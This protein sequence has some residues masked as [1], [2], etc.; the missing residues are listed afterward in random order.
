MTTA[1]LPQRSFEQTFNNL[2][3]DFFLPSSSFIR[4]DAGKW[5]NG[6]NAP[7]NIQKTEHGYALELV[8]PGFSKEEIKI[9]L[10]KN[11]LTISGVQESKEEKE[12]D[13]FI[14]KEFRRQSF[15]R[16]F[17]LDESIDAENISARYQDGILSLNLPKK[18]AVKEPVKQITI[19]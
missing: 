13:Q 8:A 15:K 6:L 11:I 1:R 4:N 10:D 19:Q 18:A 9:D 2:L 17:T 5:H 16:S 12:A 7:V 14:R 3:G